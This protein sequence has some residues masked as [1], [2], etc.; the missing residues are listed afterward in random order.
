VTEGSHTCV[1]G[2]GVRLAVLDAGPPD[3]PAIVLIHGW[4]MSR[5]VWHRQFGSSLAAEFRVVAFDLR[6]HGAS[7]VP[8]E[9]AAYQ[10][11]D[12]WAADVA[13][14]IDQLDLRRPVLVGWSYGG[15]VVN[16]YLL[17]YG[18]DRIG[19]VNYVGAI[20]MLGV[21]TGAPSAV[22]PGFLTHYAGAIADDP[23]VRERAI[24]GFL[25]DCF[26]GDLPD[27]E[28]SLLLPP[29]LAVTP[30]VRR[31]MVER[32]SFD[33]RELLADLSV[34]VLVSQGDE[35]RV[36]L[37]SAS[38]TIADACPSAKVSA[39]AGV[40]HIPFIEDQARFDRE[41][42]AFARRVSSIAPA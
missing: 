16:D 28:L 5:D 24:H 13:G 4:S 15:F 32:P 7:D 26:A 12:L 40:G 42:T 19:G 18:A 34:P 33:Y 11:P 20:A 37:P 41:L 36:A 30:V 14:V 25:A 3:A 31:A 23:D 35:D 8:D 29:A 21:R 38:T 39:Y 2:G 22:G 17:T 1:G 27:R 9:P 10:R 6:G